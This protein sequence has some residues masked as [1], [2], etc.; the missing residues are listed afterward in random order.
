MQHHIIYVPGILDD[1]GHVQSTLV[2][3]WRLQ[4]VR[5]HTHV[6][7]WLGPEDYVAKEKK[8]LTY[9]DTLLKQGHR[10]SLMGASAGATAVLNV[11]H[12]RQ[13]E[14]KSVALICPKVNDSTNIGS[15][16]LDK[17]PSFLTSI[18][19]EEN[20]QAE[21]SD[22]DKKR[23]VILVSPRDGLVS[24]ADSLISG[25]P[26]FQLPPLRHNAAIFYAISIGFPRIKATLNR[27][28]ITS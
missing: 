12:K 10:V 11:Y 16:I 25:V 18:Q 15:K 21:L 26:T 27:L 17:N 1:I 3:T 28:A 23:M 14:I 24:R 13:Q 6:M 2:R 9:T 22:R 8:L 7:P 19:L 20:I 5:G 4:G